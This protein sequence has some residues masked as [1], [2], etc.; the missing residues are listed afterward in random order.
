VVWRV[1][2]LIG[3]DSRERVEAR[4]RVQREAGLEE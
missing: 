1:A 2:E 4:R 3:V